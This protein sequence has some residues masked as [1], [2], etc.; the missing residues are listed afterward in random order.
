MQKELISDWLGVLM[1]KFQHLGCSAYLLYSIE[2][3]SGGYANK[4]LALLHADREGGR[5][6][7]VQLDQ[8]TGLAKLGR[9]SLC[10]EAIFRY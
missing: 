8:K 1:E 5:I 7:C 3:T 10:K 2:Q 4:E 6:Y 9:N